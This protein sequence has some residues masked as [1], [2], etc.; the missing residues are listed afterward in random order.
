MSWE[1]KKIE[2][3]CICGR[4]L[5]AEP[6]GHIPE[7][8]LPEYDENGNLQKC[9]EWCNKNIVLPERAHINELIEYARNNSIGDSMT[10]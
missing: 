2:T 7:P 9:C 8:I 4:I 6:C 5:K 1:R 3:C 10:A